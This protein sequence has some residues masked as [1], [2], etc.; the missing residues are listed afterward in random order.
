MGIVIDLVN[1]HKYLLEECKEGA[2][3]LFTAIGSE[4]TMESGHKLKYR[5]FYF[6]IETS[7]L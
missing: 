4:R 6:D 7:L 2:T 5:K 1:L 3:G